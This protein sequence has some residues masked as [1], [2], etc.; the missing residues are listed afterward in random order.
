MD[1]DKEASHLNL[2]HTSP[3]LFGWFLFIPGAGGPGRFQELLLPAPSLK[4]QRS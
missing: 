3:G 2:P 1:R 4:L